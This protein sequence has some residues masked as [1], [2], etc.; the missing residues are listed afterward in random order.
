MNNQQEVLNTIVQEI[1]DTIYSVN[2]SSYLTKGAKHNKVQTIVENATGYSV[3]SEDNVNISYHINKLYGNLINGNPAEYQKDLIKR[4][5]YQKIPKFRHVELIDSADY[6]VPSLLTKEQFEGIKERLST[7]DLY[8]KTNEE[9]FNLVEGLIF[10]FT[11][12]NKEDDVEDFRQ[13]IKYI[14]MWCFNILNPKRYT[15]QQKQQY[16]KYKRNEKICK[17]SGRKIIEKSTID[18]VILKNFID[19]YID[20][21]NW[22]GNLNKLERKVKERIV[23]IWRIFPDSQIMNV[24]TGEILDE[25]AFDYIWKRLLEALENSGTNTFYE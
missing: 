16:A 2:W 21:P 25:L 19:S 3:Y 10:K 1:E 6:V 17:D 13:V 4:E 12:I 14:W 18:G 23:H 8:D 24:H 22:D 20:N 11:G 7:F 9:K 15:Q 5:Q